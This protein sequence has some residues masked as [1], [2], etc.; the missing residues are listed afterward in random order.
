MNYR[1]KELRTVSAG[2]A[3]KLDKEGLLTAAQLLRHGATPEQRKALSA[4]LGISDKELLTLV[5]RSDLS[6]IKGIGPVY[7]DLLEYSGVDTVVELA[8][9]VPENLHA[10]M[11]ALAAEH[12]TKRAPR[13]ADVQSWVEQAGKL[14]RKVSY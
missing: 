9:R 2:N 11:V 4:K 5:N 14:E 7:S 8:R 12:N 10:K 13:L 6:R 3:E 1:L